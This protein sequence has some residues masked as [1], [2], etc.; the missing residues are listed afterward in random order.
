MQYMVIWS[1]IAL[2][3]SGSFFYYTLKYTSLCAIT[4]NNWVV[5]SSL[6]NFIIGKE[7]LLFFSPVKVYF[8]GQPL[9]NLFL[10]S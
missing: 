9:I 10:E 1:T 2:I 6:W 5:Q 3:H 8:F 7:Q 4:G